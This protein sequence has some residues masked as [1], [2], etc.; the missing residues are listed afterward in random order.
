MLLRP[1]VMRMNCVSCVRPRR[2]T[3]SLRRSPVERGVDLVEDAEGRRPVAEQRVNSATAV[4]AFA[5]RHQAEPAGASRRLA[6][7]SMPASSTSSSPS[8]SRSSARPP[9][10]REMALLEPA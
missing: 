4:S 6:A 1:W 3:V 9:P 10:N 8:C 7:I 5:A 2:E